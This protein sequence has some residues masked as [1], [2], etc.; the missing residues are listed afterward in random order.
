MLPLR[1]DRC[2]EYASGNWNHDVSEDSYMYSTRRRSRRIWKIHSY[3]R[4]S[5][6]LSLATLRHFGDLKLLASISHSKKKKSPV[7]NY[8]VTYGL[9]GDRGSYAINSPG[10]DSSVFSV[11]RARPDCNLAKIYVLIFSK[12]YLL[13]A[14]EPKKQKKPEKTVNNT[15]L[16]NL[17]SPDSLTSGFLD[18]LGLFRLPPLMPLVISA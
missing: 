13:A 1:I 7:I 17:V 9:N 6:V 14:L 16:I 10:L 8:W 15:L 18:F 5:R 2:T 12:L 3:L 11:D 4:F